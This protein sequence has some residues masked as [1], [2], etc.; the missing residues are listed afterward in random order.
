A[1]IRPNVIVEP[2][3]GRKKRPASFHGL[4]LRAGPPISLA[5]R[6]R[7][8]DIQAGRLASGGPHLGVAATPKRRTRP[9]TLSACSRSPQTCRHPAVRSL[10]ASAIAAGP[11]AMTIRFGSSPL[12]V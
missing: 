12:S 1:L 7:P 10:G 6:D 3:C 2:V 8:P 4:A 11:P 9:K 5:V